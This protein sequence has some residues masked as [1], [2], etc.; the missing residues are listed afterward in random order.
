MAQSWLWAIQVAAEKMINVAMLL[1]NINNNEL[2]IFVAFACK[3][4]RFG[5]GSFFSSAK[6]FWSIGNSPHKKQTNINQCS[7]SSLN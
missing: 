1:M 7:T 5:I 6:I 3:A 2:Q 4:K